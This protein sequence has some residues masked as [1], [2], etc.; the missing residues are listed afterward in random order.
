MP[1]SCV[2]CSAV[3]HC[4]RP[5]RGNS[6]ASDWRRLHQARRRRV[7][8]GR[9][10]VLRKVLHAAAV[11][12]SD[13][14]HLLR[15]LLLLL[16]LVSLLGHLVARWDNR[17]ISPPMWHWLV[18]GC[19]VSRAYAR[20]PSLPL[21]SLLSVETLELVGKLIVLA[22]EASALSSARARASALCDS[23]ARADH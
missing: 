10:C 19:T 6:R 11:R 4:P 13:A 3:L 18:R 16:I 1:T 15:L 8:H 7:L 12:Y 5:G 21:P 23:L 20:G 22:P 14:R 9:S 17:L 2:R